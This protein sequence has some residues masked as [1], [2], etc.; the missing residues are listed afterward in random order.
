ML[1][2]YYTHLFQNSKCIKIGQ[3]NNCQIINQLYW[4]VIT[5]FKQLI[6]ILKQFKIY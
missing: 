4:N 3:E 5:I 6:M 2:I 1:R